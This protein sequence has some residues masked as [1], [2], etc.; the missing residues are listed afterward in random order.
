MP[1]PRIALDTQ[2]ARTKDANGFLHVQ[3]NPVTREQVAVY[4]GYEIP[5]CEELGLDPQKEYRLYRPGSELAKAAPTICRLP[6]ELMHNDTDA[7]NLPKAEIIGALGSDPRFDGEYLRVS[8]C[9]HDADAI[10]RIEDNELKE[11]SLAYL[12][13]LDMTPG[14]WQGQA[15]DGIMRNLRGNHLALVDMGR[16]GPTVAVRDN[17]PKPQT[18]EPKMSKKKTVSLS[19]GLAGRLLRLLKGRR[20]A[21]DADPGEIEAQEKA[22]TEELTQQKVL[23]LVENAVDGDPESEPGKDSD[24]PPAKDEGDPATKAVDN[25]QRAQLMDL[26]ADLPED[27]RAAIAALLEKLLPAAASDE[28]QPPKAA[29]SEEPEGEGK[30]KDEGEPADPKKTAADAAN[31]ALTKVQS[32][33]DAQRE[34]RPILGETT[35]NVA[36]DSAEDLYRLALDRMG[37]DTSG[38]PKN[39]LRHSFLAVMKTRNQ[40]WVSPV[41]AQD[42]AP[43]SAKGCFSNLNR[44]RKSR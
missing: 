23:E 10:R 2:S 37:I 3:D 13:D 5:Q 31:A 12:Y 21:Q 25:E 41:R 40:G 44:L 18:T 33:M 16:A 32:I 28:E 7:E 38:M 19:A 26:L 20:M 8:L 17:A 9:V 4:Y 39:A 11:L 42:A 15:Y 29:D 30:A 6:L 24:D 34:T 1:S 14:Q 22:L 35:V 36:R 43:E 27:K